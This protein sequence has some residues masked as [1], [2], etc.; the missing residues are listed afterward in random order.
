MKKYRFYDLETC[1][2]SYFD[3]LEGMTEMLLTLLLK[4]CRK[5]LLTEEEMKEI[6][7]KYGY[8]IEEVESD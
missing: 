8:K 7:E 5:G 4:R 2:Y 1:T 6:I 3:T